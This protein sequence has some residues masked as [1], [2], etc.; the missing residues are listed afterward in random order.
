[1]RR[2]GGIRPF[3]FLTA[4][5]LEPTAGSEEL[6]SELIAFVSPKDGATYTAL[7]SRP[8]QRSWGSVVEA[9]VRHH[10]W[11]YTFD[12]DGA[13]VRRHLTVRKEGIKGLGKEANRIEAGQVLG[14]SAAGGRAKTY[15][16]VEGR[17][18]AMGRVEARK[19]GIPWATV[20]RWKTKIRSGHPLANGHGGKSLDRAG[21]LLTA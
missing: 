21:R 19:L 10:D 3:T 6:R 13:M 7:M 16:D 17:V 11:K 15:S 20:T 1:V 14:Q 4:R 9:F 18:L 5:L 12:G 2:L 8:H